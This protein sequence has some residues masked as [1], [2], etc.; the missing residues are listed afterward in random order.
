MCLQFSLVQAHKIMVESL[1]K[2]LVAI[3]A[4]TI[5]EV[6]H[7]HEFAH[8][9]SER[10]LSSETHLPHNLVYKAVAHLG[11]CRPCVQPLEQTAHPWQQECKVA[12]PQLSQWPWMLGICAGWY[13]HTSKPSWF[14]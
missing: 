6:T 14:L 2:L 10:D 8:H 13:E 5:A 3:F 12:Q 4:H 11:K 9:G 7:R 1:D